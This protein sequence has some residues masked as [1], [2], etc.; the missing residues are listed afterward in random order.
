MNGLG[1][2]ECRQVAT[3]FMEK[4]LKYQMDETEGN[5]SSMLDPQAGLSSRNAGMEYARS[6]ED[7]HQVS[8]EAMHKFYLVSKA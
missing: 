2:Q 8:R 4:H 7:H 1:F 5:L 6:T 3:T